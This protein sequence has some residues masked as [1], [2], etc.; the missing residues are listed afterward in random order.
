MPINFEL[1]AL[2]NNTE[3]IKSQRNRW[4]GHGMD[5]YTKAIAV[6]KPIKDQESG[7]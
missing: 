1:Y 3:I 6:C 7:G 4:L 2:N 5:R